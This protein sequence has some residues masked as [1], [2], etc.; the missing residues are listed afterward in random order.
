M[1]RIARNGDKTTTG[2]PCTKKAPCRASQG[3][4]FVDSRPMLRRGD[5]VKPHTI[6]RKVKGKLKCIVHRAAV[7]RG[8]YSVFCK[9]IPVA[10]R[11][12]RADKGAIYTA[13]RGVFA[14]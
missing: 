8:S 1:P 11:G 3:E 5:R 6:L 7:K 12:D 13:S 2:H 14:G 4:V 9:G 10:R